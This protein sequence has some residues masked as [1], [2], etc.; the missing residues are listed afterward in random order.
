MGRT[1]LFAPLLAL[2]NLVQP[3]TVTNEKTLWEVLAEVPAQAP[4]TGESAQAVAPRQRLGPVPGFTLLAPFNPQSATEDVFVKHATKSKGFFEGFS[5]WLTHLQNT[6]GSKIDLKGESKFTLRADSVSGNSESFQSD[7]YLGRG[8]NGFYNETSLDVD[9]TFLKNFHYRTLINNNILNNANDPNYNR[10]Q[11][12]YSTPKTKVLIGDISAGFQGNSLINF[13]RY[14]SGVQYTQTW[15]SKLKTSLLYS[16]TR[17]E[18]RTITI[19][20]NGSA[21]PYYVYAGQ[22]VD[23]SAK[24]R[25]NNID[26][27]IGTD[28]TLDQY[29]GELHFLNGRVILPSDTIAVTFETIGY[30]QG[31]GTVYGFRTELVA[32]KNDTLGF[33]YL[34]Q[35]SDTNSALQ[36]RT[37]QFYGF[38]TPG[39][40]YILDAP[41]DTTQPISVKVGGIPLQQGIDYVVDKILLNQ[42]RIA[43][44]VP[45]TVL[46]EITY[47][48][49]N[50]SPTPGNRTVYGIDNVLQLGSL[51][52]LRAEM[53]TSGLNLQGTNYGGSAFQIR[54]DL[55]LI[56][57]RKAQESS[58]EQDS[59][60]DKEGANAR[61]GRAD[62]EGDGGYSRENRKKERQAKARITGEKF[63]P[64]LRTSLSLRDI[65]PTFSSVQ[66]ANFNRNE[67]AYDI[68]AEYRPSEGLRFNT[69]YQNSLRPS[70]AATSSTVT[71]I[72][73]NG[74][75]H[76]NQNTL[77]ASY[78]R[79][80]LGTTFNRNSSNTTFA[81][82]GNSNNDANTLLFNYKLGR[83]GL[84]FS[85][86]S[87]DSNASTLVANGTATSL[88]HSTA[89]NSGYRYGINWQT[90]SWLNLSASSSTNAIKS[91]TDSSSAA[92][93]NIDTIA[94]DSE[95][96]ARIT[97]NKMWRINYAFNLSDTG[98]LGGN[99]TSTGAGG[100]TGLPGTRLLSPL[101]PSRD[102][103]AGGDS[104]GSTLGG[105]SNY[106]LGNYGGYSGYLGSGLNTGYGASSFGGKSSSHHL[107]VDYQLQK[108]NAG[109][110]TN[111]A[112]SIGTYQYNS[113]RSSLTFLVGFQPSK[114]V[115]FD[116]SLGT[117][118]IDYSGTIGGSSGDTFTL[119]MSVHPMSRFNVSVD[120]MSVRN[121]SSINFNA[122]T[123]GSGS[124]STNTSTNL[125][126][127]RTRLDYNLS[128][129]WTLFTELMNSNTQGYLGGKEIHTRFGADY[130]LTQ[131]FRFTFGW[132]TNSR[133][134]SD[135]QNAAYDYRVSSV[136]AE[137]GFNFR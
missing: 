104:S 105:G 76:Y 84:D 74:S 124:T 71:Q 109:V 25:V 101:L 39:A 15:S 23:G 61:P 91:L 78:E 108:F 115:R 129:R 22:I 127:L 44:A 75:D 16:R 89:T 48:P 30:N 27:V 18:T 26:V 123:G 11:L 33:T 88:F 79:G 68:S 106:N 50:T 119:G 6:T 137:F 57:P 114:K 122:L 53:A 92:T 8:S 112:S 102:L 60:A 36:T 42:I 90:N 96:R 31:S 94:R 128:G 55:N 3:P 54:A 46:I 70:Y 64:T 130:A 28:F 52:S 98:N 99:A 12:E 14:L 4:Q 59:T 95:V 131:T 97:P 10:S 17:A 58:K 103:T 136:L 5:G 133:A 38:G 24:V 80:R 67:T 121:D 45:S 116:M 135:P 49:L 47:V 113:D 83:V 132:Q 63:Q 72:V 2:G 73:T 82:G 1:Y 20:G 29:T 86:N 66:A 41:I 56:P 126:S 118:K 21:G 93:S 19:N 9:A 35:T 125:A 85:L 51:G 87:S 62:A 117:Q 40:A 77:G 34:G 134:N 13:N 107:Q 120:W 81:I 111:I 110:S 43:N 37:Q 65:S 32:T 69:S 7:S 100:G